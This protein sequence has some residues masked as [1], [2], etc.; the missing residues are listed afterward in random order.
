MA[1][2][3]VC[4]VMGFPWIGPDRAGAA[5]HY[6]T[7]CGEGT[8]HARAAT[9]ARWPRMRLCGMVEEGAGGVDLLIEHG[10]ESSRRDGAYTV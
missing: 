8:R 7:F 5:V 2:R 10:E 1:D 6:Q 9:E 3:R 4:I